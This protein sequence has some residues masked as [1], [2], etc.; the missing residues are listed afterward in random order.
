MRTILSAAAIVLLGASAAQAYCPSVPDGADTH[1]VENGLNRTVCLQ[2][3]LASSTYE[4]SVNSQVNATIGKLQRD[5][6]KQR[7]MIHQLQSEALRNNP[8]GMP[9]F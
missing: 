3:E 7:F 6:L 8:P 9:R 2:N 5:A 1:Y 4:R